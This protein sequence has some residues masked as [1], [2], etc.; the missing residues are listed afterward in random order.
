MQDVS[1]I[2]RKAEDG[3][4]MTL[5]EAE[6]AVMCGMDYH[7]IGCSAKPEI[8]PLWLSYTQA[9]RE[10]AVRAAVLQAFA[11][12]RYGRYDDAIPHA[13]RIDVNPVFSSTWQ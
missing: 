13:I 1:E 3:A 8:T 4:R 12:Y 7:T 6:A 2:I 5:A 10:D 11:A 9:E